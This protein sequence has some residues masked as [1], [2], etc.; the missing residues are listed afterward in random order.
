[1]SAARRLPE[2]ISD[3][4]DERL[5]DY[6]G[7]RGG[8]ASSTSERRAGVMILEGQRALE[9]LIARGGRLRSV[10]VTPGR[11]ARLASVVGS[12]DVALYVV[13]D[14]VLTGCSGVRLHRGVV[15]AAE[16]EPERTVAEIPPGDGCLVALEGV[17]DLENL[18][19]LARSAAA[20][21][22][23]GL[24]LCPRSADPFA[25]RVVRV[26]MGHVLGLPVARAKGW[27]EELRALRAAGSRVVALSPR[28][29]AVP[30]ASLRAEPSTVLLL[31]SEATGLSGE[32]MAVASVVARI[33]MRAGV[34]SLN[35]AAAGAIAL[36]HL[37]PLLPA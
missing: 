2:P 4:T 16:R 36:F 22:A 21:G 32:A 15:A 37:S 17:N 5:S 24:L 26:S 33:P 29:D 6:R 14:A 18:G 30:L 3:P 12:L 27:P 13:E 19:A 34:D 1:M 10:V 11:L 31:G 8:G 28:S 9:Q 25:R 7:L 35:L 23:R 20:L